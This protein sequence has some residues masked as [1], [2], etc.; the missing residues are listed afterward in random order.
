MTLFRSFALVLGV[1]LV[2]A[3]ALAQ[4]RVYQ[5]TDAGGVTHY[6]DTRPN[7]QFTTRNVNTPAGTPAAATAAAPE[8][9]AQ[10]KSVRSNL[11]RLQGGEA[12]GI[13]SNGDGTPDR[14]LDASERKAQIEL[15]QAAV[16]AYCPP[17]QQ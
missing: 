7:E 16:K 8:E 13:D 5:W 12:V 17:A 6:S 3:P 14:N 4:Q 9:S 2:A 11:A 15:N 1:A 10:C